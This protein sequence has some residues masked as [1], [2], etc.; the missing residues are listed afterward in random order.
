MISLAAD[1][2]DQENVRLAAGT[3]EKTVQV[4]EVRQTRLISLFSV[5]IESVPKTIIFEGNTKHD[6][7]VI[8]L[9]DGEL[10][11]ASFFKH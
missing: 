7:F 5:K 10:Y 11:S 4:W 8:G 3:R 1:F 2:V 6:L 9:Y